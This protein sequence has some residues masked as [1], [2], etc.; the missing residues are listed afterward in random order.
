MASRP[1]R[2][3]SEGVAA[4][5]DAIQGAPPTET[6]PLPEPGVTEG[7]SS[8]DAELSLFPPAP[9]LGTASPELAQLSE[10]T[11]AF[12][13]RRAQRKPVLI[14]HAIATAAIALAAGAIG[15][16]TT[17]ASFR[18]EVRIDIE[19]RLK[20][21][22]LA[23]MNTA[24]PRPLV[25]GESN[26]SVHSL[27][28]SQLGLVAQGQNQSLL[29][30]RASYW[31]KELMEA[32]DRVI[33]NASTAI[34]PGEEMLHDQ[35]ARLTRWR[36][37]LAEDVKRSSERIPSDDPS[38]THR[39]LLSRWDDARKNFS[40][41]R[42]RLLT[43]DLNLEQLRNSPPPVSGNVTTRERTE[44]MGTDVA[45]QEDLAELKVRLT[46][47]KL[48]M[49]NA[50]Q[51]SAD[52][53]DR[54][55]ETRHQL[56]DAAN[57]LADS[58]ST[59][60]QSFVATSR[61]YCSLFD[62]FSRSWTAEFTGLRELEA[63][64]LSREI[65]DRHENARAKLRDFLFRGAQALLVLRR[66]MEAPN[67]PDGN[68]AR[69]HV[70]RSE[71]MRQYESLRR[72][73]DR[74]EFA[75]NAIEPMRNFRL[76]S[77]LDGSRGLNRRASARMSSIDERLQEKAR[78]RAGR[79]HEYDIAEAENNLARVRST[80]DEA[81]DELISIQSDI[82]EAAG[83][84]ETFVQHVTAREILRGQLERAEQELTVVAEALQEKQEARMLWSE[85]RRA[86]AASPRTTRLAPERNQRF[87][88]GGRAVMFAFFA[89]VFAQAWIAV[90]RRSAYR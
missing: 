22:I 40:T 30:S 62:E 14:N 17:P 83:Q 89:A 60:L 86:T 58:D 38:Q 37:E 19:P 25:G 42:T 56:E 84:S 79:Q 8:Q 53:L 34:T 65:L 27:S 15:W 74:F 52:E 70:R 32:G 85:A 55:R 76:D 63:D 69:F 82:N 24:L 23:A 9:S 73:H 72:T 10:A 1:N 49:L 7:E 51:S 36:D 75:A 41:L 33:T 35:S 43:A 90:F 67:E 88:A 45:L 68:L 87:I 57:R 77:A 31:A 20:Q 26:W 28:D 78:K 18:C 4:L 46:E 16:I 5:G 71:V 13:Q 66:S 80:V 50:W 6:G 12:R 3:P 61:E 48:H 2:P 54:L 44:A 81:V 47:L 11:H 39:T 29:E 21:E 64:P 59:W